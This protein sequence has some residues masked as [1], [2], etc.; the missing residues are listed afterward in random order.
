MEK[1][2]NPT[3]IEASLKI[4]EIINELENNSIA[5]V[6]QGDLKNKIIV[7]KRN[8]SNSEITIDNVENAKKASRAI[9]DDAGDI[10]RTSYLKKING[11]IQGDLNISGNYKVNGNIF[12]EALNILKR[13]KR[14]ALG[15]I[16]FDSR[17]KSHLHLKCVKG[18]T[19]DTSDLDTTFL[20]NVSV[21]NQFSDGEVTWEAAK[22]I[23][24][25]DLKFSVTATDR[26]DQIRVNNNNGREEIIT[27][28][29]VE[30]A[31]K[32][33]NHTVEEN[34]PRNAKFTDT[35]Y[36]GATSNR[37]GLMS[38]EDKIKLDGIAD[39]AN[40]TVVDSALNSNSVNP[41][42]NKVITNALA[43]K[44]PSSHTHNY[45]GSS[46][47][48]GSANTALALT[49]NGGSAVQPVYFANGKPVACTYKLEKSVPSNAV[50]TDTTYGV[51]SQT[52]NGLLSA[53]DK[54]KLDS[55]SSNATH[56]VVDTSLNASSVN[57]VQNK[58]ITNAINKCISKNPTVIPRDADLNTILETGYYCCADNDKAKTIKNCP[59]QQ[60]FYLEVVKNQESNVNGGYN[61]FKQIVTAYT[62]T[63]PRTFIRTI[64]Q[65]SFGKWQEF[66]FSQNAIKSITANNN[67]LTYTTA[68]A[69]TQTVTIDNVPNAIHAQ[70]SGKLTNPRRIS[71]GGGAIGT[72]VNFDGTQNITIPI[73]VIRDAN[74]EYSSKHLNGYVSPIDSAM[75]AIHS[76]N[77]FC[78]ANSN[79]ITIEYSI[80]SGKTWLEYPVSD[81]CKSQ[82]VSGIG[83]TYNIGNR[84]KDTTINDKLRITLNA[85]KM[86]VYIRLRKILL[87]ISVNYS[88]GS[89]VII[90]T[91]LKGSPT[92]F[93]KHSET[94]ISGWSG[95]NTLNMRNM[96]FGGSVGQNSNYECIRLT[97]GIT[98]INA[99]ITKNSALSIIDILGFGD[100][101][102][103]TP[104]TM[105]KIGHIYD[106]NMNQDAFFPANVS[107]KLFDGLA[108]KAQKD[109]REQVIDSTY[110]KGLSANGRTITVTKGDGTTST[111]TTQDTNDKVKNDLNQNAKAYITGTTSGS[112]NTG[113]QIFDSNVFLDAA[114]GVLC[115]TTFR[116]N[117]EGHITNLKLRIV[118]PLTSLS[119]ANNGWFKFTGTID[120]VNGNW[121][122]F[123]ADTLYQATNIEDPRIVLNSNNLTTWY[124]P[125]AYWHA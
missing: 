2:I 92:V 5:D 85:T 19:T 53:S 50:F 79:G 36:T 87:N 69:R 9:A 78:F 82:L 48:S 117:L 43:G 27:V 28:N 120:G 112:S 116:G 16:V 65:E 17:L 18:G 95:W 96:N 72:P 75:S 47:P 83:Y 51:A 106:Y 8:G 63:S 37:D 73:D 12:N 98:G 74:I 13:N 7:Q 58:A 32:V 11:V 99:D 124:S 44:S 57:P 38:K 23:T 62:P 94:P 76:A 54:K 114:P 70:S 6:T 103:Q 80:D 88:T 67:V 40:K 15:D 30:N 125:Y 89:N 14:Y 20:N 34:V 35:T 41:V 25:S 49:T 55:I 110:I 3:S 26:A 90:E 113:T 45:A 33:N 123:K 107:A 29:N 119:S 31:L 97:F 64:Y 91:S 22:F 52:A 115:A 42:Q 105:A 102:W 100:A 101:Y 61:Q 46:S 111:I 4:N 1:L 68:N 59:L 81:I 122:I 10:I 66:V 24:D 39:G 21:G 108:T 86:G 121:I 93:T 84:T 77:R 109:S 56:I 118:S 60:A 71:V 104:S